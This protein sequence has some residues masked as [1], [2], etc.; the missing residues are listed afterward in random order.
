MT[1]IAVAIVGGGA[2]GTHLALALAARLHGRCRITLFDRLGRFGR[3]LAYSTAASWHRINVPAGKMGG[4]DDRDPDGFATWLAQ[5]G[6]LRSND[7]AD[8]FVPRALYGDYLWSL[9]SELAAAG[10]LEMRGE[11][12]TSV[13]PQG[14]DHV[15]RTES[16]ERSRAHVVA[17]CLG[18]PAPAALVAAMPA[19]ERYVGDVWR[20]NALGRIARDDDVLLIGT[21]ATAIDVVLDLVNR[22]VG[23]RI[24]MISRRGM[25]PRKDVQAAT[26]SAFE[27]LDLRKPSVR[28]LTRLLRQEIERAAAAGVPWQPVLDAFRSH[29]EPIWQQSSDDERRRF[30]RHLRSIWLVHRHRLAPDIADRLVRL[31]AD[32]ILS[33]RPGRLVQAEPTVLGFRATIAERGG[34]TRSL[35]INWIVNCSGPEER[36]ERLADPLVKQLL[37]TGRGRPG[38]LQMG[39]DVDDVGRLIDQYG[40]AQH[41]LYALGPPTRGRFWEITAVPWIRTNA[42]RIAEHIAHGANI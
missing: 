40:A 41:G 21:G 24:H 8:A 42:Q 23:R 29:V 11:A 27:Q 33:V 32:R 12:I 22:D 5:H 34:E 36:Y 16:G 35:T 17:L 2:A 18:N 10:T 3:G 4:R 14:S 39:L 31:Q 7:H 13:E 25:L 38:P 15:I 26:Y 19:S 6:H 30:L 9:L 1:G 20:P 28:H 37:V